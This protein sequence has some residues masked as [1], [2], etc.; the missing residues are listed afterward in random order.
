MLKIKVSNLLGEHKMTQKALAEKAGVRQTTI[1]ALY[2]ETARYL[3]VK[4][5]DSICRVLDCKIEDVLEY[6]PEPKGKK[7]KKN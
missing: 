1:G 7:Q 6:I 5:L 3:N 4:H 2:H